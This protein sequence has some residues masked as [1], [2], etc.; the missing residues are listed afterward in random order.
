MAKCS[1]LSYG[2]RDGLKGAADIHQSNITTSCFALPVPGSTVPPMLTT[3]RLA[4][5]STAPEK[6]W[7]E[8]G[9]TSAQQARIGQPALSLVGCVSARLL[10]LRPDQ[11]F[12]Y[13]FTHTV[14]RTGHHAAVRLLP[15]VKPSG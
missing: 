12:V 15:A 13:N 1:A 5:V 7:L 4:Q 14:M 8:G 10:S 9:R 2:G 3:T 11:G 6:R